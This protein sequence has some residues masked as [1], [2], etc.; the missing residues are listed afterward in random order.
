MSRKH[1]HGQVGFTLVELAIVLT[2]IAI[3][4]LL[5][6]PSFGSAYR[7]SNERS[8]VQKFA[9]DFQWSRGAAG[10]ADASVLISGLSGAPVVTLTVNAD[11]TWTVAVNGTTEPSHSMTASTLGT[12]APGISCASS[13]TAPGRINFSAQ[14][15]VDNVGTLTYTGASSRT[16]PLQILYSGS[17]LRL[18]PVAGAQS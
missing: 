7:T 11:C 14:G 12:V 8:V 3:M 18:S 15:F 10:A 13:L 16:Y 17:V 6:A 1:C 2:I 4:V 9:Q 5:A